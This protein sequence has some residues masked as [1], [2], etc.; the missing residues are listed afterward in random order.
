MPF[1]KS[2]VEQ[3]MPYIR[4]GM[5]DK[6]MGTGGALHKMFSNE[7]MWGPS[8]KALRAIAGH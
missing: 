5:R 4:G 3:S 1:F 2:Y 6:I 7:N 8:P